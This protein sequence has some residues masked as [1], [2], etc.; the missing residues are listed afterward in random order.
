VA[1]FRRSESGSISPITT[2]PDFDD[3]QLAPFRRSRSGTIPPINNS[4]YFNI[5]NKRKGPLWES[6]FR[7][8]N[9][10][11]DD[12]LLHLTRYIHLNPSTANLVES[13]ES[14]NFS[15]F[16]EYTGEISK[17]KILCNYSGLIEMTPSD[18]REF[19]HSRKDYQRELAMIKNLSLE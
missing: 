13:P 9:V 12:Q 3:P 1:S 7:N 2:W 15:S 11:A 17:E 10:S 18:Y 16:R 8:V 4:R 6:R 19:V 14:W 5:K